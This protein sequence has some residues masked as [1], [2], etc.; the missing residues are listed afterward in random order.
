MD[1]FVCAN[2]FEDEGVKSFIGNFCAQATDEQEQC[3]YCHNEEGVRLD[4]VAQ[5]IH[6]CMLLEWEDAA[7][8]S[9]YEDGEYLYPTS[10]TYDIVTDGE[11]GIENDDLRR[12]IITALPD[13]IWVKKDYLADD[14]APSDD[15]PIVWNWDYFC[16]HVKHERRYF[17]PPRNIHR[18]LDRIIEQVEQYVVAP[19]ESP[20]YRA[21]VGCFR[22]YADIKEPPPEKAAASNRMSPAGIRM[23]YGC[24]EPFASLRETYNESHA[25]DGD[26]ITVGE[27]AVIKP[28]GVFDLSGP[29]PPLDTNNEKERESIQVLMWFAEEIAKPMPKNGKP[30]IDYVPTQIFAEYLRT[31]PSSLGQKING[32]AYSS[33][34]NREWVCVALFGSAFLKLT[35]LRYY[36]ISL[37]KG[38]DGRSKIKFEPVPFDLVEAIWYNVAR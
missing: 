11:L 30:D 8:C 14:E 28:F 22:E 24:Y 32:I 17:F 4:Y 29:W 3:S 37:P 9:P 10:D 13:N 12:D 2:C 21:R 36:R 38:K 35:K 18:V 27:F 23:F 5:H 15:E 34:K 33:A 16:R 6:E 31:N 26:I 25:K 7:N 19:C 20:I 1:K